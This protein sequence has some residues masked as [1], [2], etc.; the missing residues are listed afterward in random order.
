MLKLSVINL[1]KLV[2][3]SAAIRIILIAGLFAALFSMVVLNVA[4]QQYSLSK[5]DIA[6]EDIYAPSDIVDKSS[7][8]QR[9]RQAE[10]S[11]EPVY[12]LDLTVQVE[13]E[14]KISDFFMLLNSVRANADL[15]KD[16]KLAALEQESNI[17]LGNS[18]YNTLLTASDADIKN[19][20]DNITYINNQMLNGRI[21]EEQLNTKRSEIRE[22][23]MNLPKQ[24]KLNEIGADIAVMILKPNMYYDEK[25]TLERKTSAKDKVAEVVIRKGTIIVNKGKEVTSQQ[26][27]LLGAYGLLSEGNS[28]L[29]LK[30]YLGYGI[31][32]IICMAIMGFYL[33][34]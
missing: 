23:F 25:T 18:V 10:E 2:K 24:N 29:D 14:K 15:D 3:S 16:K 6:D 20:N 33:R 8:E 9:R 4:P 13:I 19:L 11:V 34:G 17:S 30:F 28:G 12:K 31:I 32:I 1:K 27:E 5:G 26:I 7:T 22:F 21:T